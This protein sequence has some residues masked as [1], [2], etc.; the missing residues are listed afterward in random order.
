[1]ATR[2]PRPFHWFS[3]AARVNR[4][5]ASGWWIVVASSALCLG[6]PIIAAGQTAAPDPCSAPEFRQFDF[7]VGV[8]D[9]TGANGKPAG[10]NTIDRPYGNCVLQEH[11]IGSGGSHGTS[12]NMYDVGRKQWHQTWVDDQG[13]LVN[14]DG[15]F[16]N[17]TMTMTGEATSPRTGKP[18]LNR[19]RWSR[20]NGDPDKVR[21]TW[22]TST[23]GGKTWTV[24]F[25][26]LYVRRKSTG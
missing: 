23:D 5:G 20:E 10:T 24:A 4:A 26:G 21:Q 12:L 8:W 9:V 16:V 22:D 6:A 18:Y 17:G 3:P 19:I 2:R 7:W 14:L 11:W 13:Q 1:M 15:T 25:D